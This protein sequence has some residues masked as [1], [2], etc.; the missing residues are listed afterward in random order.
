MVAPRMAQ[1]LRDDVRVYQNGPQALSWN[2]VDRRNTITN[3]YS[4]RVP[5]RCQVVSSAG[6]H[7]E[8]DVRADGDELDEQPEEKPR[9]Q[10]IVIARHQRDGAT[11][12]TLS[13][14]ASLRLRKPRR[15][16]RREKWRSK[17]HRVWP[18]E[19]SAI[20]PQSLRNPPRERQ[21]ACG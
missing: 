12:S 20:P 16:P 5:G 6:A 10:H 8:D 18:Q 3:G 21:N 15:E 1:S 11:Q 13:Y 17:T 14:I 2:R 4:T 9:D 19:K 7:L